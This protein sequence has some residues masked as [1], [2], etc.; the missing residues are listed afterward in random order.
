MKNISDIVNVI[1]ADY[2]N[3]RLM[4]LFTRIQNAN[5]VIRVIA[6]TQNGQDLID[7]ASTMKEVDVI[8]MDFN[9]LDKTA[10]DIAGELKE[11][12]PETDVFAISDVMSAEFIYGAKT[13]GVTEVIKRKS[14]G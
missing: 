14:C 11:L 3:Q 13:K 10:I 1:L 9:L 5:P 6:I 8:L 4:D 7:R 2:D 12:S